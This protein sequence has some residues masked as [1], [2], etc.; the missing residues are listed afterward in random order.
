MKPTQ[1]KYI[2]DGKAVLNKSDLKHFSPML[3]KYAIF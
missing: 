2:L 1:K 3:I